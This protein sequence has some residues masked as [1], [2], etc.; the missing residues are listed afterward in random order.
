M[1]SSILADETAF[2]IKITN[3]RNIFSRKSTRIESHFRNLPENCNFN[4]NKL[5]GQ[6]TSRI[7]MSSFYTENIRKWN[8][9]LAII[10]YG[11]LHFFGRDYHILQVE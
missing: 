7:R 10:Q 3:T 5:A 1:A 9:F 4:L 2:V 6:G 8:K 11:D